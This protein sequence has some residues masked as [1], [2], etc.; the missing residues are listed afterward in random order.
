[1]PNHGQFEKRTGLSPHLTRPKT[2]KTCNILF[3]PSMAFNQ[4]QQGSEPRCELSWIQK[5]DRFRSAPYP[6][7]KMPILQFSIFALCGVHPIESRCVGCVARQSNQKGR[8][9]LGALP[10]KR[11]GTLSVFELDIAQSDPPRE[12]L[13]IISVATKSGQV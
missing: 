11:T 4:W 5:A 3:L 6:A 10:G 9:L 7:P 8:V 2:V 13:R 1:M 12:A